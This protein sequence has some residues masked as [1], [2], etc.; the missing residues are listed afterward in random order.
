MK[1][2]K[3]NPIQEQQVTNISQRKI[4][5]Y[6]IYICISLVQINQIQKKNIQ[7]MVI[8][9]V[10]RTQRSTKPEGRVY[11]IREEYSKNTGIKTYLQRKQIS[12]EAWTET[13][14][15]DENNPF[16]TGFFRHLR[17]DICYDEIRNNFIRT[18]K[19]TKE[20]QIV[21][22]YD[23]IRYNI[24]YNTLDI[25]KQS[26]GK[27][28][29]ITQIDT[30]TGKRS[31]QIIEEKKIIR[32]DVRGRIFSQIPTS[33]N[34][35]DIGQAPIFIF[36]PE[37][38]EYKRVTLRKDMVGNLLILLRQRDNRWDNNILE[39]CSNRI[40]KGIVSKIVKRRYKK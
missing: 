3:R 6:I 4:I 5:R 21:I 32:D 39:N 23:T 14:K 20:T 28:Y 38:G 1:Q 13:I 33:I 36:D 16:H 40:I 35:E 30:F 15:R 34:K 7:G 24:S 17:G 22:M 9:C 19:V 8:G 26:T 27:Q 29:R 18:G 25:T 12:E 10:G 2:T 37:G 11:P 31:D